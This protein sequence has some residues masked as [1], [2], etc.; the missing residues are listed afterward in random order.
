MSSAK[1]NVDGESL[2]SAAAAASACL[3][4]PPRDSSSA[5]RSTASSP[6]AAS[7]VAGSRQGWYSASTM[8]TE[9]WGLVW[10]QSDD[11]GWGLPHPRASGF[12]YVRSQ[13]LGTGKRTE[14]LSDEGLLVANL[15]SDRPRLAA[16]PEAVVAR[17]GGAEEEATD[18]ETLA[19]A[20]SQEHVPDVEVERRNDDDAPPPLR[21]PER[22][23]RDTRSAR[24]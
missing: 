2:Q 8:N 13:G 7:C 3:S 9:G 22:C 14:S 5:S 19:G 4:L 24:N 10:G 23:M 15:C 11:D 6:A 21:Q 20:L 1:A 17:V 12:E 18:A 16:S